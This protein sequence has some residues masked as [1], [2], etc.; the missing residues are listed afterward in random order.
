M[1]RIEYIDPAQA[2]DRTREIEEMQREKQ[3]VQVK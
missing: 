1:A 2:S 3:T